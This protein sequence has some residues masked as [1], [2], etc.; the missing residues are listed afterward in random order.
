MLKTITE[1]D[2]QHFARLTGDFSAVHVDEEMMS[3][4]AFGRIITHGAYLVGLMSAASTRFVES[5]DRPVDGETPVSLGYDRVRFVAPVYANQTVRIDY[6][7]V[8]VDQHARRVVAE[9]CA[10][11]QDSGA[12]VAVA[13][14]V[15]KWV[16]NP[17]AEDR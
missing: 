13:T 16:K 6:C 12:V 15:L 8:D 3:K 4:S 14:N 2:I 10:T 5:L 17:E 1:F 11:E 7:I 9:V